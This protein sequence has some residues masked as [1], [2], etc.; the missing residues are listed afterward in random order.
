MKRAMSLPLKARDAKQEQAAADQLSDDVL[1]RVAGGTSFAASD[2]SAKARRHDG[3]VILHSSL[4]G[5][6]S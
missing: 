5:G 4:P 3:V 1:D 6:G 2:Q